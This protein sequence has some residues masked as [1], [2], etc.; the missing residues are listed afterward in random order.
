[1]RWHVEQGVKR[2]V[3][4]HVVCD[5]VSNSLTILGAGVDGEVNARVRGEVL[6]KDVTKSKTS[7]LSDHALLVNAANVPKH[8][9]TG[10]VASATTMGYP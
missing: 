2:V 10:G 6:D 4:T 8:T 7:P 3:L 9:G 5:F 1:M